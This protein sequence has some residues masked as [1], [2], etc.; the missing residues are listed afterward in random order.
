MEEADL[1][2]LRS[3]DILITFL[4]FAERCESLSLYIPCEP[5]FTVKHFLVDHT[6]FRITRTRFFRVNSLKQLFVK[7]ELTFKRDLN[8]L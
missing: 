1:V 3:D 8:R 5:A 7:D 2:R 4:C 6:A